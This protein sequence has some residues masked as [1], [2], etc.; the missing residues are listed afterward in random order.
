MNTVYAPLKPLVSCTILADSISAEGVRLTT[1]ELVYPRFIHAEVMTHRMFSRNASS[2]RAIPVARALKMIEENPAVPSSWRLNEKGMQG[3]TVANEAT[4]LAA[5]TIWLAAMRDAVRHA[6]NMDELG[7]H[8]Q[9]VNRITEPFAHIKTVMTGVFWENWNVLRNHHAADPTIETLALVIAEARAASTPT[10]L[11]TG[12]WHLPYVSAEERAILDPN[13]AIKVSAARCARV[14]YNNNTDGKRSTLD[15]DIKLHD[16]LLIDQ[17]IHAS[18]AE[19][20]ATPDERYSNGNWANPH[21]HGN[22]VGYCQYRKFLANE[23]MDKAA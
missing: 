8:K 23:N 22:L 13:D 17:P 6:K 19:H 12:E 20:Q 3:Y 4:T 1:V 15:K 11:Q 2:S 7:I 9:T 16:S 5:E 14:S 10:L 18:P 21:R